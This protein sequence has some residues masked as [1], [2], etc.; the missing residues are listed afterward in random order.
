M[1]SQNNLLTDT[2]LVRMSL[3][4]FEH[5]RLGA[6]ST[7]TYMFKLMDKDNYYITHILTLKVNIHLLNAFVVKLNLSYYV[8]SVSEIIQHLCSCIF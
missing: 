7:I 1:G 4:K 3:N 6:L 5:M 2:T 8:A